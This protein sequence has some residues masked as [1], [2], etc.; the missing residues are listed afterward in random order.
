M[1]K[2][3]AEFDISSFL[4]ILVQIT[5]LSKQVQGLWTH[6]LVGHITGKLKHG[7]YFT[8]GSFY[9]F[10]SKV[11]FKYYFLVNSVF[12]RICTHADKKVSKIKLQN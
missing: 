8:W 9:Q 10:L 11:Y 12:H 5:K 2:K 3:D 6:I 4:K 7:I 1:R